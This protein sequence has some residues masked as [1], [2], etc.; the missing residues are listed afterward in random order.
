MFDESGA[1]IT[2]MLCGRVISHVTR[3]GK[4]LELHTQDGHTVVLQADVSGDIHYK[5]QSVQVALV[6]VNL[7][8]SSGGL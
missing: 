4:E 6:G 5:K 3:R 8:G 2:T 1:I 7:L